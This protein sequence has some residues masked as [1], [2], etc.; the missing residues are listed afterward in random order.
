MKFLNITEIYSTD[1]VYDKYEIWCEV[2]PP[3]Q[4]NQIQWLK[5]Q[6]TCQGISPSDISAPP[7]ILLLN[8]L[9]SG[10]PSL[11]NPQSAFKLNKRWEPPVLLGHQLIFNKNLNLMIQL[12]AVGSLVHPIISGVTWLLVDGW[13]FLL[14]H[15]GNPPPGFFVHNM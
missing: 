3:W 8:F 7:T 9:L 4:S 6:P 15:M 10:F 12:T 1:I 11:D 5:A 2:S 14:G 13:R